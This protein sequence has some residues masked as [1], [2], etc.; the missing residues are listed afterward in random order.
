M[1]GAFRPFKGI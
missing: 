1:T